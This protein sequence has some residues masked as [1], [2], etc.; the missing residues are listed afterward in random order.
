LFIDD[1]EPNVV[2]ARQVGIPSVH[3]LANAG[4]HVLT[5]HLAAH[6]IRVS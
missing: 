6:G 5:G 4:A 2:T 3:F 1:V